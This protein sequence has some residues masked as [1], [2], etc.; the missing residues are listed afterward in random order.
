MSEALDLGADRAP[1]GWTGSASPT[2]SRSRWR[3]AGTR[4]R[5][6]PT[7]TGTTQRLAVRAVRRRVRP[8]DRQRRADAVGRDGRTRAPRATSTP[9]STLRSCVPPRLVRRGPS[10]G[11]RRL[12]VPGRPLPDPHVLGR[13][14]IGPSATPPPQVT[15]EGKQQMSQQTRPRAPPPGAGS[16]S[17]SRSSAGAS[18][19]NRRAPGRRPP[20][21]TRP[22]GPPRRRWPRLG[23][24]RCRSSV[25]PETRSSRT[26]RCC[27]RSVSRS[28]W[29]RRPT[30]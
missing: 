15:S 21:A 9:L 19:S 12:P 5:S 29:P 23:H 27:S 4:E 1:G 17:P 10:S 8:H 16:T 26:W 25:P 13:D 22:A 3:T 6:S 2:A 18:C 20:A 11:V 24:R 28:A 7:S 14:G 30:A